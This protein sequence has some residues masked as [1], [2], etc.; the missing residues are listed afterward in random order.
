MDSQ[1]TTTMALHK[2]S[3][4]TSG[5][6]VQ[7][8]KLDPQTWSRHVDRYTADKVRN[9]L[10][11]YPQEAQHPI[12]VYMYGKLPLCL[13]KF[14]KGVMVA[15][16]VISD[17]YRF[18]S[19][20]DY[21]P[22]NL[23]N[24]VTVVWRFYQ[25]QSELWLEELLCRQQNL[26]PLPEQL[27]LPS[28]LS[29]YYRLFVGLQGLLV[30]ELTEYQ[31][32][33]V[34]LQERP[35]H[36]VASTY[37]AQAI[38]CHINQPARIQH[39]LDNVIK[40]A[41]EGGNRLSVCILTNVQHYPNDLVMEFRRRGDRVQMSVAIPYLLIGNI[42]QRGVSFSAVSHGGP[43]Q[44]GVLYD[45][46]VRRT[47]E[48]D[49]VS[50]W[51]MRPSSSDEPVRESALLSDP[52]NFSVTDTDKER[53]QALE[54]EM[55]RGTGISDQ[56]LAIYVLTLCEDCNLSTKADLQL[57]F[58]PTLPPQAQRYEVLRN[59]YRLAKDGQLRSSPSILEAEDR[60]QFLRPVLPLDHFWL[61]QTRLRDKFM[62]I[63]T[64]TDRITVALNGIGF[65]TDE[66]EV[67]YLQSLLRPLL[68]PELVIDA[69]PIPWTPEIELAQSQV[70]FLLGPDVG[71]YWI[72]V[73]AYHRSPEVWPL[74]HQFLKTQ[75]SGASLFHGYAAI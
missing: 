69:S 38:I 25:C 67:S 4:A 12:E 22:D 53:W 73:L 52:P 59:I 28:Y 43:P 23:S 74:F 16:T 72:T 27:Q 66:I 3:S 50:N 57:L 42:E 63:R 8:P 6:P 65:L 32:T 19:S 33:L 36:T 1:H 24:A 5:D 17:A 71:G 64:P 18:F 49:S 70:Q 35:N 55:L 47:D 2:R 20:E 44:I 15:S 58:N 31:P 45:N 75:N 10:R 37:H 7:Y 39:T 48:N 9:V 13:W 41:S 30:K 56:L 61:S 68:P 14:T 54:E 62:S 29:D 26:Q 40:P 34:E 51:N 21:H 11:N 46:E 60:K